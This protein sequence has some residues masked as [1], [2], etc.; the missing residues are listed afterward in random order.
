M[1]DSG[2]GWTIVTTDDN[3]YSMCRKNAL[4]FG[5][6]SF[7]SCGM[8]DVNFWEPRIGVNDN[9]KILSS[10][11]GATKIYVDCVPWCWWCNS[12]CIIIL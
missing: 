10:W 8:N 6:C 5:D 4:E 3:R 9:Q 2:E 1:Y 11:E 12:L 7:G